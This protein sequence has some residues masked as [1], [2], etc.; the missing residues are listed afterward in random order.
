MSEELAKDADG[1]ETNSGNYDLGLNGTTVSMALDAVTYI[2]K[3]GVA[4]LLA[5]DTV[6]FQPILNGI[7]PVLSAVESKIPEGVANLNLL[8]QTRAQVIQDIP[9]LKL[10]LSSPTK[11]NKSKAINYVTAGQAGGE[12]FLVTEQTGT[13]RYKIYEDEINTLIRQ[14]HEDQKVKAAEYLRSRCTTFK[15]G[16]V[17]EIDNN[18]LRESVLAGVFASFLPDATL[19]PKEAQWLLASLDKNIAMLSANLFRNFTSTEEQARLFLKNDKDAKKVLKGTEEFVGFMIKKWESLPEEK[20]GNGIFAKLNESGYFSNPENAGDLQTIRFLLFEAAIGSTIL[21]TVN[22]IDLA[23]DIDFF[24]QPA[25]YAESK[26]KLDSSVEEADKKATVKTID[27][28]R[29]LLYVAAFLNPPVDLTFR[30]NQEN[31][32]PMITHLKAAAQRYLLENNIER[33]TTFDGVKQIYAKLRQDDVDGLPWFRFS[34]IVDAIVKELD[35]S[36]RADIRYFLRNCSGE[37]GA[38]NIGS[39]ILD[40]L[41]NHE[42]ISSERVGDVNAAT[43]GGRFSFKFRVRPEA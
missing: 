8:G 35:L 27:S 29:A 4:Y 15:E 38:I 16:E 14:S 21:N 43:S 3:Q 34:G 28:K 7:R 42:F 19:T 23:F 39:G 9:S 12:S 36:K 33:P 11:Y 18:F 30:E 17:F 6:N 22:A 10:V 25:E 32:M 24:N 31:K 5:G 37:Q 20:K 2:M 40:E 1:L 41:W 26:S 13:E